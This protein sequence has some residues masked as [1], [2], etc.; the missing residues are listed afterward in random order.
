M[1]RSGRW[2]R[3]R[4]WVPWLCLAGAVALFLNTALRQL[5]LPGFYYDEGFDLTPMLSLLHGEPVALLR[6]IGLRVGSTDFPLMRRDY[7]GSLNGY[8]T[9]PFMEILGPGVLAARLEPIFCVL[10]KKNARLLLCSLS[11]FLPAKKLTLMLGP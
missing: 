7:M 4:A 8:L 5:T 11:P 9:L 10:W 3:N 2:L 1:V 6:G